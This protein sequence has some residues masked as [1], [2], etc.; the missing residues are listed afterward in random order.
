MTNVELINFISRFN[1]SNTSY[2][3]GT[4]SGQKASSILLS[5][6]MKQYPSHYTAGRM[7]R[8][9]EDIKNNKYVTDCSGLIK[10]FLMQGGYKAKYDLNSEMLL[11][12][13]SKKGDIKTMP[14]IK[15]IGLWRQGHVA[16][17][18]GNGEY[19]EAAGF[20]IGIRK[21]T[22]ITGFRKWFYIPYIDYIEDQK[23]GLS[24]DQIDDLAR[25]VIRGEFKNY[26]ERKTLLNNLGYGDIYD[27]VQ[28][29]V[30]MLLSS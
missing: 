17:Y 18:L 13:S 5:Q 27:I 6:K 1:S 24:I 3:Y 21:G 23:E 16:I 9:Q 20:S 22:N 12:R 26:P 11:D 25:R 14:D 30:N 7:S 15:G 28:A 4:I 19:I 2:W 29:R 10:G 8:Y